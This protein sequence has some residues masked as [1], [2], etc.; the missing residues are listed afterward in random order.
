MEIVEQGKKG[1]KRGPT[2]IGSH[3]ASETQAWLCHYK[4]NSFVSR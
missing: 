1:I 4:I 2:N 3:S